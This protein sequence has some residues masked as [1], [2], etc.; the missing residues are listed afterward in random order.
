MGL[1]EVEIDAS[2]YNL[3]HQ[4]SQAGGGAVGDRRRESRSRLVTTHR[5]AARRAPGIPDEAEFSEVQCHDLNRTGF[6]F[7]LPDE[8]N[9]QVIVVAFGAPP[10]AIYLSAKVTHAEPVLAYE[11]GLIERLCEDGT[12]G[13]SKPASARRMVLVGCT[14][15]ERLT[16]SRQAEPV[17][18]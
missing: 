7:F 11:S 12:A 3:V 17:V 13:G 2:F 10:N 8:P 1:L 15:L 5:I 14:F 18:E 6:S 16:A 4:L 9:F